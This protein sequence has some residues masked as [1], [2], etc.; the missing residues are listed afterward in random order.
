[1][2]TFRFTDKNIKTGLSAL[3]SQMTEKKLSS[4]ELVKLQGPVKLPGGA[5]TGSSVTVDLQSS[6]E[7][8]IKCLSSKPHEYNYPLDNTIQFIKENRIRMPKLWP[9]SNH[10]TLCFS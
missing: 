7:L 1:M 9:Y 6:G 3:Q 5:F 8:C 4:V 10:N 2:S